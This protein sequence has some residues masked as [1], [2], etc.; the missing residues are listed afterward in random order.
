MNLSDGKLQIYNEKSINDKLLKD[1]TD[2]SLFDKL[3]VISSSCNIQSGS[4]NRD[5][6]VIGGYNETGRTIVDFKKKDSLYYGQDLVYKNYEVSK[7]GP[8]RIYNGKK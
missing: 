1:N 5:Y 6:E 2:R 4:Y 3:N 7:N 8:S